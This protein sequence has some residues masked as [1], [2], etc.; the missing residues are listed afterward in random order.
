MFL[1]SCYDFGFDDV[2]IELSTQLALHFT[3]PVLVQFFKHL[4]LLFSLLL[5]LKLA[6]LRMPFNFILVL[7]HHHTDAER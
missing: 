1:E 3:D 6:K 2:I 7:V 4:A 5:I